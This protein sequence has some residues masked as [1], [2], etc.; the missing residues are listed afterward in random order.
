[1]SGSSVCMP[2]AP[3]GPRCPSPGITVFGLLNSLAPLAFL[4]L[5]DLC[6]SWPGMNMGLFQESHAYYTENGSDI[7][8]IFQ[9]VL[10]DR[11]GNKSGLTAPR[12]R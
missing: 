4:Q 11:S 3:P 12:C 10:T 2:V 5:P 1:M 7:K 9:S 8:G 6:H